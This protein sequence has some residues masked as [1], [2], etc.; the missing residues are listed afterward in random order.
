MNPFIVQDKAGAY[1][2]VLLVHDGKFLLA[3]KK[4][5]H[6][7]WIPIQNLIDDYCFYRTD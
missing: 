3:N 1:F 6:M 5:F 2:T 7:E 4:S